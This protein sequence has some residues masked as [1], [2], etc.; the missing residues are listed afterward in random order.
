MAVEFTASTVF[1]EVDIETGVSA[2]V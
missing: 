2:N 1:G